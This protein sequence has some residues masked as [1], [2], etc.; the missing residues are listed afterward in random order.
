M[1]RIKNT[2]QSSLKKYDIE[3]KIKNMQVCKLW[4]RVVLEYIPNAT[5]KT[6]AVGFEK[7]VLKIATL[8][9]EIADQIRSYR[10]R[11]L[12]AINTYLGKQSVYA[13]AIEY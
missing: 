3:D 12:Y 1:Q 6:M 2:L 10:D 7:G 13:I 5:G 4:E 11:L 8:S 9:R